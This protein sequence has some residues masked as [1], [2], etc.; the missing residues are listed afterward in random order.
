[1][2]SAKFSTGVVMVRVGCLS[3]LL[4][5]GCAHTEKAA[6][7][8]EPAH[9]TLSE[10]EKADGF[11]LLFDGSTTTGWRG[12]QLTTVPADW[13][14]VDGSLRGSGEGA[15]LI[16]DAKFSS[17][18]LRF[19]FNLATGGNSGVMYRVTETE[20]KS[21]MSGPEYQILDEASHKDIALAQT[22]AANYALDEPAVKP[23]PPGTWNQARIVVR[24]SHVEHW[25]NG[26]LAVKYDLGSDEWKRKVAGSKF[27]E[28]PAFGIQTTGHLCL[29]AHGSP[30]SFRDIKLR[31]LE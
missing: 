8:A 26:A 6:P 11:H 13:T 10:A 9:N 20:E 31:T 1:M 7:I 19:E 2:S 14:V 5:L 16:T 28:W 24:G 30:V 18:D 17:F 22:T 23:N 3:A 4:A 21:Y 12:Y 15:D 25:L 29:Q 27:G